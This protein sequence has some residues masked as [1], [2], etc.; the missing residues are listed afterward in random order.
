MLFRSLPIEVRILSLADIFEALVAVD[1]PYKKP[2]SIDKALSILT[3]MA[4][5]GKLDKKLV[6]MFGD[7]IHQSPRKP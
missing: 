3:S 5:E 2:M 6:A 7:Y 1:R 4:E